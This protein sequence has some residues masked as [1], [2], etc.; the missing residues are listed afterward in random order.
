MS[1][2]ECYAQHP[3]ATGESGGHYNCKEIE[4][5]PSAHQ[6]PCGFSWMPTSTFKCKETH[7]APSG[8]SDHICKFPSMHK[9]WHRCYCG[10]EWFTVVLSDTGTGAIL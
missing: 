10:Y 1:D 8:N 3:G 7:E 9:T 6:C 2:F 4:G 5:H